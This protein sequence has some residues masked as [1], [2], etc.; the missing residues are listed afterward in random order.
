MIAGVILL[1][2]FAKVFKALKLAI[3]CCSL[4]LQQAWICSKIIK[5]GAMFLR[6]PCAT[7]IN[8]KKILLLERSR[9]SI[10]LFC[11]L[12]TWLDWLSC[13][14]GGRSSGKFL[15]GMFLRYCAIRSLLLRPG[16]LRERKQSGGLQDWLPSR[17]SAYLLQ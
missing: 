7:F 4:P 14:Y 9:S 16:L 8:K 11:T 15:P 2:R 6:K 13:H 1:W 3:L 12:F 10:F 5:N 17:R